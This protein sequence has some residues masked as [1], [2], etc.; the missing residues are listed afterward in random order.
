VFLKNIAG[1]TKTDLKL[2]EGELG[3]EIRKAFNSDEGEIMVMVQSALD[4]VGLV[5]VCLFGCCFC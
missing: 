4:E 5:F 2:P 1:S 3:E